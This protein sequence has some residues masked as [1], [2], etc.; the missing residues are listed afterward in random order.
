MKDID[1]VYEFCGTPGFIAPEV[2]DGKGYD[3]KA[4]SFSLG[5]LIYETLFGKLP[6]IPFV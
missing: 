6:D 2:R 3:F 5:V 1:K 4:D